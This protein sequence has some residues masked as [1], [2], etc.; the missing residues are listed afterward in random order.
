MTQRAMFAILV[1]ISFGCGA[2]DAASEGAPPKADGGATGT[3][4]FGANDCP[5]GSFCN[6]FG[7][8]TALGT[9]AGSSDGGDSGLPPEVEQQRDPPASGKVYV[10]VA[11]P[12]QDMVAKIHSQ[13]LQVR[14]IKVGKDPGVLRTIPG[15]DVAVVL[16]RQ[17]NTIS[18]LRSRADGDDD[19]LT[20]N[21]AP[22]LNQLA[23]APG[24]KWAIAYFDVTR[25]GGTISAKQTFQ[26]VTV[27]H[28]EAGK[29][30]AVDLTVGFRP[31]MIQFS[32]DGEQA[33]VVTEQGVSVIELAKVTKPAIVPTVPLLLD[34]L[35]EG[36]LEEVLVTGDG[37]FAL[38]RRAGL[39]GVRVVDLTTSSIQ[40]IDLGGDATDLDLTEDGKLAV[41]VLRDTQQVA[42]IDIPGDLT[43][44]SQIDTL[45]TGSFTAGQAV[46]T[47]D[48]KRAF[49]FTNASSQEVLL[50]ADLTSR[51]I[52]A[53]PLKKGV[54]TVYSSPDGKTALILHNKVPGTPGPTDDFETY[55]DKSY[56]YSLLKVDT[57]FDKLL[58]TGTDPGE[59]AFDP[60]SASAY[61]LL[62]DS[63]AGIRSAEAIDLEGFLV[64][65]VALGS[66]P[67]AL[68]V[69]PAT[70]AVYVAQSHPLG[71]VTFIDM[72]DHQ[73]RTVTGFE[74]NSHIIE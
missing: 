65:S 29:E 25:S 35:A 47:K 20:L 3:R 72:G 50:V 57:S 55:L 12:S 62:G 27:A 30:S 32:A 2:E 40:D 18:I 69:I 58:L 9:D 61:M 6:E 28:L 46:L 14:S 10:Y 44:P 31:S 48:G 66:P 67:V 4:C 52:S 71:R 45:A 53:H 56:G 34:P 17:S 70:K 54:R 37:A 23:L 43:D 41:V 11:V 51:Q 68:G 64:E 26:E 36:K 49:L 8:C 60:A 21:V 33:Y 13:T 15:Q 1:T 39:N 22:G 74:L 5:P 24:G 38:G 19:I 63:A 59:V 7:Y 42:L 73:T 16:S